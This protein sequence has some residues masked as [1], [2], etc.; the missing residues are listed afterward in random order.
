[1]LGIFIGVASVIWL[2]AIGEGI[3]QKAQEQIASLG[4]EQHHRP[5]DQAAQ[6]SRPSDG[7]YAYGLTR[8]DFRASSQ[9]IPTIERALADPRIP[10]ASSATEPASR[11]PA[12]RLHARV[13]RSDPA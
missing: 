5:L 8:D 1:M 2:L 7:V 6:R 11:R 13:C 9:T 3:S 4:A 12:G 10:P